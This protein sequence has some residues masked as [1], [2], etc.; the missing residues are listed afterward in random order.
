M[1]NIYVANMGKYNEGQLVGEW[2][3]LP[4][5]AL[6]L[7]E[8][9]KRIGIGEKYE[10]FFIADYETD[11][12][13]LEIGEC[14]PIDSLNELAARFEDLREEEKEIL[15]ALLLY[16]LDI[17]EGFEKLEEGACY[18]YYNCKDMTDVAH[19]I[20]DDRLQEVS[21]E[22]AMYFDFEAY[23]RDLEINGTFYQI[24]DD[25]IEICA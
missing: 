3:E 14:S 12:Q 23:G 13:G 25:I 6:K 8:V 18:V 7:T 16:G 10:E 5:T 2:I 1:L 4:K 19:Q 15:Q 17:E 20:M 11:I 9:Y 24:K 21:Q 22:I